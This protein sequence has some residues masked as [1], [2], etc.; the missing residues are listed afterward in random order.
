M[1]ELPDGRQYTKSQA[2]REIARWR[3]SAKPKV[4][5]RTSAQA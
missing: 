2:Q 3:N 1:Q 4:I 5:A